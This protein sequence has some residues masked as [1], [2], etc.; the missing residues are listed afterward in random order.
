MD[1]DSIDVWEFIKQNPKIIGIPISKT[2]GLD[3]LSALKDVYEANKTDSS[4]A[5][6]LLTGIANVLIAS[7]QGDGDTLVEEVIVQ[8]AMLELDKSL[9]G[10]LNEG[11]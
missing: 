1:E 3:L 11:H 8:D 4:K 7:A 10:I 5:Q 6:M 2:K 9:K